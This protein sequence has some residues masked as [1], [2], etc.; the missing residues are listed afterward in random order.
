MKHHASTVA[1]RQQGARTLFALLVVAGLNLALQPCAM[2][3]GGA[4]AP[5]CPHCPPATGASHDG[6]AM[7]E[8]AVRSGPCAT[9]TVDCGAL[10]T[11]RIDGRAATLKAKDAPGDQVLAILPAVA[12]ADAGRWL[13]RR[14][15]PRYRGP[16]PGAAPPLTI[17]YCS[18]L[19]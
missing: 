1:G 12:E 18:F 2:A 3:F 6:H 17:L 16:D 13:T 10:D 8:S 15:I 19:K 4:S 14:A 7:H 11:F 5:L 9:S